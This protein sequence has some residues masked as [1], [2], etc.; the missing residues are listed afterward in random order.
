MISEKYL[1]DE[2]R[3]IKINDLLKEETK[4][5]ILASGIQIEDIKINLTTTKTMFGGIR[6]WFLCPTC[7]KRVGIIYKH[8]LTQ[9]LGCR[10]CLNLDY[11]K[12]RYKGMIEGNMFNQTTLVL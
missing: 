5:L 10:I 4:G 11:R 2:T 7:N 6:L 9:T 12:H 3:Q 1:V 8:P